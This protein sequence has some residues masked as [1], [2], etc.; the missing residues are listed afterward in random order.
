MS[1]LA[2]FLLPCTP[3]AAPLQEGGGA[4]GAVAKRQRN[5]DGWSDDDDDWI[6]GERTVALSCESQC[7]AAVWGSSVGQQ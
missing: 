6:E 7:G 4:V 5:L 2:S 3:T 1:L